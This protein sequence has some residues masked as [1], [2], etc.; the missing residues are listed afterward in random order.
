V[1]QNWFRDEFLKF[2]AHDNIIVARPV[3]NKVVSNP[4][5][6]NK[7]NIAI[8]FYPSFA[9]VF[10]NFEVICRAAS[11]LEKEY[12][13]KFEVR[14]TVGKNDNRYARYLFNRYGGSSSIK[15]IGRISPEDVAQ[16]YSISAALIF[17]S[18]LESWGLPL[19]EAKLYGIP[20]LSADLP[21]AHEA[22]APYH[23]V[24]FFDPDNH[25]QLAELMSSIIDD[26]WVGE[27]VD[28]NEPSPP[29]AANWEELIMQ[30]VKDSEGRRNDREDV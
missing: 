18:K 2:G 21:Y 10:K 17:P 6:S 25:T 3:N 27:R 23:N 11:L 13:G 22:V 19:S 5:V 30:L 14:I 4:K 8:F 29:Y 9:R 7:G 20:I 28:V 26:R 16:N 15:F 24:S 1:Q 12:Y